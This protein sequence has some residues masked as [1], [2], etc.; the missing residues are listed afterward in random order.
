MNQPETKLL[1][2]F[3]ESLEKKGQKNNSEY[4]SNWFLSKQLSSYL[5]TVSYK[6]MYRCRHPLTVISL[7]NVICTFKPKGCQLPATVQI[8]TRCTYLKSCRRRADP[9]VLRK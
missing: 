2:Q 3:P 8:T 1:R 4:N 5:I 6:S 9:S 7:N